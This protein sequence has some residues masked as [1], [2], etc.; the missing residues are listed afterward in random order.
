MGQN[1]Q[2]FITLPSTFF[3]VQLFEW[4]SA[5]CG[6][7]HS[8]FTFACPSSQ[9]IA[10]LWINMCMCT[11]I[12]SIRLLQKRANYPSIVASISPHCWDCKHSYISQCNIQQQVLNKLLPQLIS[13]T[14]VR[15]CLRGWKE[16]MLPPIF[17][18]LCTRQLF[19]P[20]NCIAFNNYLPS[21]N[22]YKPEHTFNIK[23]SWYQ[24]PTWCIW[25]P[26]GRK[27]E[28]TLKVALGKA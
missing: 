10:V 13:W 2:Q 6:A 15:F 28:N 4:H 25:S 9:A 23:C 1:R 12:K 17:C 3:H 24:T 22:L 21:A 14:A 18:Y 11:L 26:K 19:S 16:P 20:P 7:G 27:L 8:L 5:R